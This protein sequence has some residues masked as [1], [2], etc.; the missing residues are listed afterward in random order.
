MILNKELLN[1]KKIK[2]D[3]FR[4]K[5][6]HF[7]VIYFMLG[8]V[9]VII[10]PFNE[11]DFNICISWGFLFIFLSYLLMP[12]VSVKTITIFSEAANK[13]G[14]TKSKLKRFKYK[15]KNK[16]TLSIYK[17]LL[18]CK[19]NSDVEEYIDNYFED[20]NLEPTSIMYKIYYKLCL[21]FEL[22]FQII[23]GLIIKG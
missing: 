11:F 17:G 18:K 14:Y 6:C 19:D 2:R 12:N 21:C 3:S 22:I 20:E 8:L 5:C 15:Y 9:F 7:T 13:K 23:Y 16:S 1:K 10:P 4:Q